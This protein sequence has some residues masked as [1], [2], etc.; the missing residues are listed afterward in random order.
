MLLV[1]SLFKSIAAGVVG[2]RS[3]CSRR[4]AGWY[5]NEHMIVETWA[6]RLEKWVAV[7]AL[8]R[9][10]SLCICRRL[11]SW[12]RHIMPAEVRIELQF[13]PLVVVTVPMFILQYVDTNCQSPKK[14]PARDTAAAVE[15][16]VKE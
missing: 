6:W 2:E 14:T 15:V 5:G 9:K 10:R 1:I 11:P 12:L 8:R 7:V 13:A 3:A 16:H 4:R